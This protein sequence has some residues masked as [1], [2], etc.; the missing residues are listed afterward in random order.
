MWLN[1]TRLEDNW[2]KIFKNS[3]K[4]DDDDD[5]DDDDLRSV[6]DGPV[7]II[8]GF[9]F[10]FIGDVTTSCVYNDLTVADGFEDLNGFGVR[11]SLQRSSIN[12]QYLVTFFESGF[13][14]GLAA[15]KD[16]LDVNAH[17]SFGRIPSADDAEAEAF[18]AAALLVSD[19]VDVKRQGFRSLALI[20]FYVI[21]RPIPV[22]GRKRIALRMS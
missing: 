4:D 22:D 6:V 20:S 13:L 16:G 17:V 1:W 15:G 11:Q 9:R 5:G 8:A 12:S 21:R 14:G 18:L 7:E 10:A 3:L 19:G 2:I